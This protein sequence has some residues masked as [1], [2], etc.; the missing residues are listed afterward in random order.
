MAKGSGTGGT[1]EADV[2]IIGGGL[3]GLTAAIGVRNRGLSVVVLEGSPSLGGRARSWTDEKTG[4]PVHVGPHI[5]LSEYPNMRKLLA[6]LGTENRI[7]WQKD[8]FILTVEGR[9]EIETKMANIPAPFHFAPSV[10]ADRTV[11][12]WDALSNLPLSA[13]VLTLTEEDILK[14]DNLN[15]A[16]F[17]RS[18]G[19]T[20]FF[21][22]RFW[23]FASMAIMNVPVELCSAG[24]L[25]RF[26]RRLIGHGRY[27]VGFADGG[28]GDLFCPQASAAIEAD[29]G[30]VLL[31][32][33]VARIVAD[34]DRVSHVELADGSTVRGQQVVAALPPTALRPLIDKRWLRTHQVFR[35]LVHFRPSPY[36]S[37]YLWFDRKL[38]QQQFWARAYD[39]NDLNCDFYDLS[40]TGSHW[41]TKKSVITTNCI[42][43]QRADELTDEEV[44]AETQRELA[45]Y[46]PEAA[47]AKIE[48][49]VV[50]RIPMAIHCPYPGTEQKRPEV[51]TPIH[52]LL[53]AGDW[54]RTALP[55][56]MESA[57]MAGWRVAEAILEARGQR[58]PLAVEHEQADGLAGVI[59]RIARRSPL[60]PLPPWIG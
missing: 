15:A 48:H 58:V 53:L 16:G 29:G 7:I 55:S 37:T 47:T 34:G 33:K 50:S 14:L 2:V 52:N 54:I 38:T 3:A 9:Q 23:A 31:N 21:I 13:W 35:D 51:R 12:H 57:C 45:E 44:I 28:L 32:A 4:H 26:Y 40:N 56:S 6:L 59:Y 5:F 22:Q 10:I 24:A 43:C 17:L 18:M 42:Y 39:P 36:I 27:Q 25:M 20:E 49:A 1:I 19:V 11:P 8:R 41:G 46:L 60:R 30:R